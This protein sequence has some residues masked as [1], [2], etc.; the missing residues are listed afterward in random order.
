M[1]IA[2]LR[3]LEFKR[4]TDMTISGLPE[5]ARLVVLIG[6]NG[7]GKSSLFEAFNFWA[8][9]SRGVLFDPQYHQKTSVPPV[10][11]WS[12]THN[13]I[14]LRFHDAQ[15]SPQSQSVQARKAFYF[16]SA[17]RHE[18][19]FNIGTFQRTDDILSDSKRPAYLIST[20]A[21]VADDYQRLVFDSL[22]ALYAKENQQSVVSTLTD[23][24]VGPVRGAMARVFKDLV[25]E[26]VGT[27]VDHGTF[28]FEKGQS[29]RF[30][31]KNLSAG[32]KSA[33][34][35]LLDFVV[36]KQEFN[37]TIFCIDEP[38]AHI[39]TRLQSALL[40][41][42]YRQIPPNCQLWIAT[43]SI[44]MTYEASQLSKD[45]PGAVIFLDFADKD[46]D[47]PVTIEPALVDPTFWKRT[48]DVALGDLAKLL[49]PEEIV[50]CEGRRETAARTPRST[51]DATIYR[52][53]FQ[54]RHPRTD[55]V[56]LG[57]T[58]EIEKSA[59]YLTSV[60]SRLFPMMK[61]W[62]IIDR[63]DRS[64]AEISTLN[65]QGTRVL[66]RRDVE[67]YLWDDEIL[68]RLCDSVGRTQDAPALL[69]EK[70][71][72]LTDSA[73]SGNPNDDMKSVVGPLYNFTKRLL[74]LT[75]CG[76]TNEEFAKVTLAPLI[77]PGTVTYTELE[78]ALFAP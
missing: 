44:G 58:S 32:E 27:P 42:L 78:L 72:L 64:A 63:D 62:T 23:R 9:P 12:H 56:P 54:A 69:A 50:F 13:K 7:S 41:E 46:F 45:H 70:R 67:N 34:D 6:P 71:K 57:G 5:S 60:F 66:S 37:D 36:K 61:L 65:T 15:I 2:S 1:K 16:R 55:F 21:R 11:N 68:S 38:E 73:T 74:Q 25:L 53:I 4:F 31:Y 52:T 26:G 19:D 77:V 35:L 76:N 39:N 43:H 28:L 49:A 59:L 3:V 51:F 48:F 14:L 40:R 22:Q 20:D 30:R 17:Y 47:L 29:K 33:F 10:D 8:S 24:L 75:G 18:P